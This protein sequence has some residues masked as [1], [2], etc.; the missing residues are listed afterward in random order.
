[1]WLTILLIALMAWRY[2]LVEKNYLISY[3]HKCMKKFPRGENL[4]KIEPLVLLCRKFQSYSCI[5]CTNI[6]MCKQSYYR[7][8][9]H[10]SASSYSWTSYNSWEL[11]ETA[12]CIIYTLQDV[13]QHTSS[14]QETSPSIRKAFPTFKSIIKIISHWVCFLLLCFITSIIAQGFLLFC[15]Y[16]FQIQYILTYC[17]LNKVL[18][19]LKK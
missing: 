4:T 17:K 12:E 18:Y 1:M 6:H 14:P 15:C 3:L 10:M 7:T 13:L 5:W 2:E 8:S 9:C 16:A 11:H 19:W